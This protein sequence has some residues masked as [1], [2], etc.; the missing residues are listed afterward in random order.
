MGMSTVWGHH[1]H[2]ANTSI[3]S[4]WEQGQHGHGNTLGKGSTR[5]QRGHGSMWPWRQCGHG[6]GDSTGRGQL[7]HGDTMGGIT[8]AKPCDQHMTTRTPVP[9]PPSL[10]PP[11]TGDGVAAEGDVDVVVTRREGDILHC[12]APVLVVLAGHLCFRGTLDG[13]AQPSS[14]RAPGD[15][16]PFREVT[17]ARRG[18][19]EQQR[20]WGDGGATSKARGK[21]GHAGDMGWRWHFRGRGWR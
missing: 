2:G 3:Q 19:G 11:R 12:T 16:P 1:G 21:R 15:M 5:G 7:G 17:Q 4:A 10:C 9:P 8:T 18:Q 13:Q 20:R 6:G 14:A